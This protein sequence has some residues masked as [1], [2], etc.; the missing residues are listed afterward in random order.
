MKRIFNIFSNKP[1]EP[2]KN[3]SNCVFN[4][5]M[6]CTVGSYLADKGKTGICY[7]GE[8]WKSEE[9]LKVEQEIEE[10]FDI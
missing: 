6:N 5:G 4:N 3:C 1:K 8:L 10:T 9:D 2:V 7:E